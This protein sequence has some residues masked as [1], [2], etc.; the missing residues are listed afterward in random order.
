MIPFPM[1]VRGERHDPNNLL[2]TSPQTSSL[3]HREEGEPRGEPHETG[4]DSDGRS[5]LLVLEID[6]G[7]EDL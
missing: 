2:S 7:A 4:D 5:I 6:A 3:P 1:V